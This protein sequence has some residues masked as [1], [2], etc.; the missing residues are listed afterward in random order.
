MRKNLTV[1]VRFYVSFSLDL[2][3]VSAHFALL[4][5][6]GCAQMGFQLSCSYRSKSIVRYSR[7]AAFYLLQ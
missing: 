2:M 3:K 7:H 1:L 5:E 4:R 6:V